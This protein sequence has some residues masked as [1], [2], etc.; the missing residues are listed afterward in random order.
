MKSYFEPTGRLI[1]SI[2]KDL[3]KDLPAAVVE[4][5]K[6]S[7]D[8][9]ASYVKI[10]YQK[11]ENELKV[12][13]EDDGHG[14]SQDTVLNAWMVPSTDYKL[15]KKKSPKGRVYQG[16]KGIGR[17][18][19][20][21]LGNKLELITIK[22]GLKTTA[23]FDWDEFN[24][25]KKLSEIPINITTCET[26]NSSGTKL[27]ITNEYDNTLADEISEIE[28]QKV[29]KEL[30]KLLSNA[31]DFKIIVSYEN[32]Y[33]DDKKNICKEISQLEFDEAWHYKLSGEIHS[34]FSYE[35]EYL[36]FYTKE[37]KI[38]KDSFIDELPKGSASCGEIII[39]YRVYDKDPSG[40]EVIMNFVNGNQ[41]TNLS[42]TEIKNM[43]IDKSGISIFRNDF[44]IRP[45]GDKGFDWL[46]LDSKRVQNPS[47]SIGSE[48]INGK[49]GIESEEIS[50][51]KEKS[52][53]DGLYENSNFYTLQRIADLSLSLLEKERFKYR[54]KATKKKPEAID[55][56]FD[57]SH[58]NQKMEKAVE[59]AYK[60]LMKSPE[61]TDEHITLLNQ[62][63]TKEIKNL[64]KEK[65]TE[66][67]EVKETIAIYQKHTT[68][69]N[70]IS[71]VLHEG[72]KPLSW[73]TNRIP[74]IKE[75]LDN[76]YKCEEL[77]AS[78]YNKLSN[79]MKKLSD[80]AMRM[81][82]FFKRLD[83]LSSNKRG[84]CKKT[85]VQKQING[86]IELFEEIAKDKDVEIQYNS[87]EE[88][89]TNIIEEDLYMALTNIVENAMFWVK[90]SSE[91]LK[92]IE[93]MS[94]GDDDKIYIE[95]LDNGP[96][97]SKEDLEDDILFTPGYSGKKRVSDDN[98]TGLGLAIAGE[99]IQRN[100]GKL[101]V[102]E[103][104]KG[105]CF[106]ITL[107]RS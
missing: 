102:I 105:A 67:L 91:P 20:S 42:K 85:S 36:N 37:E 12:I 86:V 87:V 83:P 34:D 56:L 14:M 62:E 23:Y 9:D 24:S 35:L 30:S 58:I 25:D 16:R 90:F 5:V 51:L 55:K 84:K 39:D 49:I 28:S 92:S 21:L 76:L 100:N 47:M 79:Q 101:E 40:I 99:A 33:S 89:Y 44:R 88:F 15:K 11:N 95:I 57:F 19:V 18:A 64:E 10:T 81:S 53:R 78:S 98:G 73:Y 61:K 66:F 1:M 54:Q 60:N 63:L 4:L 45:Y 13:V 7:Y 70:V 8:A 32:F 59:K 97:I 43:L 22:D 71:V 72:R 74:T 107:L 104:I 26:T 80:E 68:L 17:Y 6:N 29:E 50:G 75:Y 52:A 103:S 69:G 96:G 82:N 65:E 3:I 46:N 27:V 94:Y 38:F 41:N 48:Q 77:G 2:G 31:K 106:R 93:I